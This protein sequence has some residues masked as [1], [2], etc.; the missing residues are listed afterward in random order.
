LG[1]GIRTYFKRRKA[2][3][4]FKQ[5]I[6]KDDLVF[7]CGANNGIYTDYF[8]S[9]NTKVICIE[10]NKDCSNYL[11]KKYT[12]QSFVTIVNKG[13]SKQI[14]KAIFN[15]SSNDQVSSFSSDFID[16]YSNINPT[17]NWDKKQEVAVT[18]LDQLINVYG[19]PAF[20]K[21]DVEGYELKVLEGLTQAIPAL[22]IEFNKPF[23]QD[24]IKCLHLLSQIDDYIFNISYYE[25]FKLENKK[26][27]NLGKMT[28]FL[29]SE[30][31][32]NILTGELYAKLP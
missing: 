2:L 16:V 29:N 4:L 3:K 17:F 22:S 24:T 21:I 32:S 15:I 10:A 20:C 11:L 8:L 5:F 26:W 13:L 14:G 23:L 6:R 19:I 28:S 30:I 25:N 27:L 12:H 9:L 18:N 7:D 1:L 31:P